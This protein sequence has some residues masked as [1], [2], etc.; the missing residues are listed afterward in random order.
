MPE[1]VA[2]IGGGIAGIECALSIAEIGVEVYLLERS[3][4]IGGHM[5][6]LDKTFPTN[7]CSMCILAPKMI[8]CARHEKIR[9]LTCSSVEKVEEEGGRFKLTIKRKKLEVDETRCKACGDCEKVCPVSIKNEFEQ[10]LSSVK[11]I[12]KEFAQAVP[13]TYKIDRRG[14]APCRAGCP[15]GVSTQAYTALIAEGR[16][17]DALSV[18]FDAMPFAGVCGR[19]CPAPCEKKCNRK[20]IDA[21]VALR[22]LKRASADFGWDGDINAGMVP[23]LK[24]AGRIG[25]FAIVG[26]GPA[27][28]AAAYDLRRMGHEVTIFEARQNAGGMLRYGIPR[29]RLPLE[30]INREIGFIEKLGI[31]ILRGVKVGKDI[32]FDALFSQGFES[33]FIGAG[34]QRGTLIG[35]DGEK[36]EGVISAIDFLRRMNENRPFDVQGKRVVIIGGGNSAV[37]SARGA[38]RLGAGEVTV[39]YR[40]GKAQMPAFEEEVNSAMEEGVRFVFL[41]SPKKILHDENQ[42]VIG[43]IFCGVEL[44]EM[45]S[46]GRRRPV[47]IAGSNIFIPADLV[48]TAVGQ[49]PDLPEIVINGEKI[50]TKN[51]LILIDEKTCETSI[52]G[53]FAGGDVVRG[54]GTVIESVADGKRAAR[55]MDAFINGVN[56][57]IAIEEYEN[58]ENIV[59]FDTL[60][61]EGIHLQD[62]VSVS[63]RTPVERKKSFDEVEIG[64]TKED[65]IREAGRCLNCGGCSRC[66]SCVKACEAGAIDLNRKEETI[67]IEVNACVLTVGFELLGAENIPEY[68]YGKIRNVITAMEMERL[69]SASGPTS[70]EVIRPSDG[71]HP[72]KV[73]FI[74]CV[75]SRDFRHRKYCSAVCCMHAVKEA[76]LLREHDSK[77]TSLVFYTDLRGTGK[78]MRE[79]IDRASGQYGVNFVRG[80]PARVIE[81]ED[82]KIFVVYE[83]TKRRERR[84]EEV[85]LVV[86][87]NA[88]IP[89]ASN[90][91]EIF[92]VETTPQG[93][94]KIPDPIKNPCSTSRNGIYACGCCI[95]PKDIPESV[96]ESAGAASI[97]AARVLS[98]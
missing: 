37:D 64:Y 63:F 30:I 70:G 31:K 9:I 6:M 84:K 32:S 40:R 73:A 67:K 66:G 48:I 44:G 1:S 21:A 45:D 55:A 79:Y 26:G 24:R 69:L 47:E 3:A 68:G 71:K 53:V 38:L 57:K 52:R 72:S 96:I 23:P 11:A 25:K 65:A 54:G 22:L 78:G 8:E 59:S 51:G 50:K 93:F 27:G 29:W 49:V 56:P 41:A 16:F 28:I 62:R 86:L 60:N 91:A 4:S 2:I 90:I 80:R 89:P 35:I 58:K 10:G 43:A 77:V 7:D 18:I 42:N 87:C 74:Q 34:A 20:E 13:N 83:D 19:V 97:A 88:L 33:I 14:E 76:I 85:D 46:T 75:G 98:Q 95:G 12:H 94:I 92:G 15:A 81:D 82:G 61:L 5:A 39:A 17:S 36:G